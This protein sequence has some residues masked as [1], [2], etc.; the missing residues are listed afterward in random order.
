MG[1][2]WSQEAAVRIGEVSRNGRSDPGRAAGVCRSGPVTRRRCV[3]FGTRD[4]APVCA[5]R[6]P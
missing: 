1:I 2:K 5:V 4:S 6:D 3:P